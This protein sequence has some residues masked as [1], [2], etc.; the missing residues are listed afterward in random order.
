MNLTIAILGLLAAIAA[1][2]A[3]AGSWRAAGKANQTAHQVAAIERQR[4]HS[5]LTPQF[6]ITCTEQ[7]TAPGSAGMHVTL[8]GPAGLNHLDE[9][10]ISI[11]DESGQDHWGHGLPQKVTSE[12][13]ALFVWGPWEFNTGA[14]AQ[15]SDN[16]TTR[17]RPYSRVS[18]KNW[19]Q[20]SLRR[21]RPGHWMTGTSPSRWE[22]QHDGDPVRILITCRLAGYDPWFLGPFDLHVDQVAT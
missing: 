17:P 13:A 9:V 11:L 20:L 3:T 18:G 8:A 16:R 7:K 19:D 6:Q 14:S 5:E 12:E 21:T 4:R 10:I 1:A 22:Q 2:V 15:V